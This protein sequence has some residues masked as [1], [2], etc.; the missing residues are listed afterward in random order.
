MRRNLN[1]PNLFGIVSQTSILAR[2]EAIS[3]LFFVTIQFPDITGTIPDVE[4]VPRPRYT[5]GDGPNNERRHPAQQTESLHMIL[6]IAEV[7]RPAFQLSGAA[8]DC[9]AQEW[10]S[11]P[12]TARTA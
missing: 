9:F 10:Q 2:A 5:T 6:Q 1:A 12:D 3:A 8:G 11:V 4:S 7:V